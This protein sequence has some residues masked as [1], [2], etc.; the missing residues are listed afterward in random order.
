[1]SAIALSI[2]RN[3]QFST[4]AAGL[5]ELITMLRR[6]SSAGMRP[7]MAAILF[8]FQILWV[9]YGLLI[10]SRPVVA[11]NTIAVLVN[12]LTVGACFY[13]SGREKTEPHTLRDQLSRR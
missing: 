5:P 4:A 1:M 9:Y 13:L 7:R 8:V 12:F 6:R 2:A 10:V 11:W 3:V